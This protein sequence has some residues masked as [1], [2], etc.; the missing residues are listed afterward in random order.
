MILTTLTLSSR[1]HEA[2]N[3]ILQHAEPLKYTWQKWD[4][5]GSGGATV[6]YFSSSQTPIDAPPTIE[7]KPQLATIYIHQ[8][9]TDQGPINDSWVLMESEI[10]DTLRWF[11]ISKKVATKASIKHPREECWLIF[12]E[13]GEPSWIKN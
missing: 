8:F 11:K 10:P 12:Q 4:F 2:S 7:E 1:P 5:H 6:W 9:Q 13:D 3:Q